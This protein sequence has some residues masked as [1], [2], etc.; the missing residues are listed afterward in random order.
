MVV[1]NDDN[2][3]LADKSFLRM[4]SQ[5]GKYI[6][7]CRLGGDAWDISYHKQSGRIVVAL[8]S[9]GIQF[10]D[11]FTAQKKI[12]VQNMKNC[13]GVVWV[14]DNVYVCGY[15]EHGS[16]G[17]INILD[18]HG[19]HISSIGSSSSSIEYIHH[20]DNNIYYTDWDNVYCIKKDGSNLF[21]FSS[22]DLRGTQGIDTDRSGN[23]YVA[24]WKSNNI[25]RLSP[26]GQNMDIVLKQEDGIKHPKTLCFS[27]D[28]KELFVSNEDGK[29]VDVITVNIKD[30]I[31]D[32]MINLTSI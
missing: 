30:V 27:R 12:I 31:I 21:T 22:P 24:G 9:N 16:C 23:V 14:D 17:R 2:L 20:R 18:S 5:D 25:V 26:D 6:K 32:P 1:D 15:D 29:R 28:F 13:G 7:E 3:I 10:V 11:S 8:R 4:Y 19:R